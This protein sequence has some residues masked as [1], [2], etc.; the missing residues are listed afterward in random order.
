MRRRITNIEQ[1]IFHKELNRLKEHD[2]ITEETY[3]VVDEAY[4]KFYLDLHNVV[5]R[6]PDTLHD[7]KNESVLEKNVEQTKINKPAV[8]KT[9]KKR[10][11]EEVRERNI[12]WLLHIGVFLLLIGGLFVATSQWD[13][14]SGLMRTSSI[15]A[16]SL[17]FYALSFIAQKFLKISKSAFA[18]HVLAS[19][20]LPIILLSAGWF[21][22][23]GSYFSF[24]GDG[25]FWFGSGG[26]LL[27][28]PV[29]LYFAKTLQ[30]RFYVWF[31]Y[32]A[33]SFFISFFLAACHL[34]RDAFF[35][36][37]I[38]FHILLIIAYHRVKKHD[39]YKL[40]TRELVY[41]VQIQFIVSS[42]LMALLFE[43]HVFAGINGMIAA[44]MYLAL[45][46]VS[47]R[48]EYH[49][50]FTLFMLYGLFQVIEFSIL[51][52]WSPVLLVLAAGSFIIIPRVLPKD[53]FWDAVFRIT[54]GAVSFLGFFYSLAELVL[55][56]EG[57]PSIV[58]FLSFVILFGLHVYLAN[59]FNKFLYTYIPPLFA[60][61]ALFEIIRIA[62]PA[63]YMVPIF[64]IGAAI[65]VVFG[66]LIKH[67][68]FKVINHSSRDTGYLVMFYTAMIGLAF[69]DQFKI[70][71]M[72]LLFT[73]ILGISYRLDD[74][75]F[76]KQLTPWAIPI[77]FGISII[78]AGEAINSVSEFY[79]NHLGIAVSFAIGAGLLFVLSKAAE[80]YR[81][82]DI[83]NIAYATAIVIYSAAILLSYIDF[84]YNQFMQPFILLTGLFVYWGYYKKSSYK[85]IT[86]IIPIVMLLGYFSLLNI[87]MDGLPVMLARFQYT[88]GS[89]ILFLS[90]LQFVKKDHSLAGG[91][92]WI[93]HLFLP[94]AL[95]ITYVIEGK[96]A[97]GSFLLAAAIYF[98]S[99]G[100]AQKAWKI[101]FFLYS[102]FLSSYAT[103]LFAM[104]LF[105]K[106]QHKEFV[107][108]II[109]IA[110]YLLWAYGRATDQKH[111]NWFLIP[112][113]VFGILVILLVYPNTALHY[114]VI[115]FY[116]AAFI[117]YL[118]KSAFYYLASIPIFLLWAGTLQFI[119]LHVANASFK[120]GILAVFA[121]LLALCGIWV[122]KKYKSKNVIF[123][124]G[125][126]FLICSL[127]FAVSL[128]LF[129]DHTLLSKMAPGLL[130]SILFVILRGRFGNK[131][132]WIPAVISF[133][134]LLQPYYSFIGY[135]YI[136]AV[137]MREVQVLPFVLLIIFG[138]WI[139]KGRYSAETNKLQWFVL[140]A[141]SF[142]LIAD[143][144]QSSTV[145]DA[146]ILGT[147]SLLSILGGFYFKIKAYFFI[148]CG[149]LLLNVLLQ[150]RPYWG[151][152]PWWAYLLLAGTILISVAS[153]H[154]WQKQQKSKGKETKFI[155]FK[156]WLL[157]K[158][159]EWN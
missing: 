90:A 73:V 2:Y 31:S 23:F 142:L 116:A 111:I 9:P 139:L 22:L 102:C 146:I 1:Q 43:S 140:A 62:G 106:G 86:F 52:T 72:L 148:G 76:Y 120:Q 3:E 117:F 38:V 157:R 6:V 96:L 67:S 65:C 49:F 88:L 61:A 136:P 100:R 103:L 19:L 35:L 60:M 44:G 81:I 24:F 47:G 75:K 58:M 159:K 131:L 46:Y 48:K 30:S 109:S 84:V 70:A 91:F 53:H 149:V 126:P 108:F 15:G 29:Y 17:L 121:V 122:Y 21:E 13:T 34:S 99:S 137:F 28:Y 113:S 150:T 156:N 64:L 12:S 87:F 127:L 26:A 36:G 107:P 119:M 37:M 71:L 97:I 54:A 143:G 85:W 147:L 89:I 59:V 69:Q 104:D 125:E 20:F 158:L 18:F 83:A 95:S 118:F 144:L 68:Y 45:I 55:A 141:V 123:S 153:Y 7:D 132:K 50:V 11:P 134:W 110:V 152:M 40:F 51:D 129:Q 98:I 135:I 82:Q 93:G 94:L 78:A 151:N 155:T 39:Q 154:E 128:Y 77:S 114:S 145:M 133:V 66:F 138:K 41:Y 42:L 74:R 4:S 57:Q 124:Y 63:S 8:K 32:I 56:G 130:I 112:W 5:R 25:R 92:A 33:L 105:N 16:V 27:L 80:R 101:K 79:H 10:S 115:L 14:M